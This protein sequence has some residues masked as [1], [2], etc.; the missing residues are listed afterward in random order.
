M[1]IA[2]LPES[3]I[4]KIAAG[5]VVERP[6]SVV[7][8]LVENAMDAG[9][10]SI[11]VEIDGGGI[12]LIRVSDDGF[13]MTKEDA[14]NAMLRH[15]TSKL[16]DAGDLMNLKTMGFRGEAL[17]T[18]AS[19]SRFS[20]LT[21]TKDEEFATFVEVLGGKPPTVTEAGG[22][23]GTT[24][25]VEDL[26]FNTPAR[27]KFL[28]T[29]RTELVKAQDIVVKLSLARPD[30]SFKLKSGGREVMRTPGMG[31]LKDAVRSVY[32][33]EIAASIIPLDFSED[34][35]EIRGYVSKPNVLRSSRAWQ[36]FIVNGRVIENRA[37]ARAI[38][39]A[40]RALNP[41]SGYP[42]AVIIV[43][44][45]SNSVDV[46]VHPQ[47]TEL[48]FENESQIFHGVYHAITDAVNEASRNLSSVAVAADAPKLK[49]ETEPTTG[50]N[51]LFVS[52]TTVIKPTILSEQPD[53]APV[54]EIATGQSSS[55][56]T[57]EKGNDS[58]PQ[59]YENN[60]D[61]ATTPFVMP[62]GQVGRCYI[63]AKDAHGLYIIDQHAAHER[64]LFDRLSR[65]AE[66]I[67]AQQLLVHL[68]L[69]FSKRE[70]ETIEENLEL[71]SKLGFTLVPSGKMVFRLVEIP[72]DVPIGEAEEALR[73]ILVNILEAPEVTAA[74]IREKL[75]AVTACRGAIK[76]GDELSIKQMAT[77]LKELSEA[78]HPYT[79]PHGR[80]TILK[81]S[82][83]ELDKMFK[84][85]GF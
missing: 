69:T 31:S 23:V 71:F 2:L 75:I 24:V 72:V 57:V 67:P 50:E 76:A 73:E 51:R 58:S 38:D 42:F 77:L 56:E 63:I 36:T 85:T 25:K 29:P 59:Q 60:I 62:I 19:V 47:K 9:A 41:N 4:N 21:R 13:G 16:R 81:F 8:E 22:R 34:D 33:A 11:E 30:I 49:P 70:A 18:I 44:L 64:I 1:K 65:A 35:V 12:S 14:R 39:N 45:P 28:K 54:N 27:K 40:Y 7:K 3:A 20:L 52:K 6:A 17:P 43:N 83:G 10:K 55:I 5:E 74:T 80:P 68:M 48:K 32:G 79:C 53:S 46:N 26:F 66:N 84:R 61:T 37:M 15:A 78:D 82:T